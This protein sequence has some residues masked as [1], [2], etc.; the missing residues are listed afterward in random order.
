MVLMSMGLSFI[1]LIMIIIIILEN[2]LVIIRLLSCR[3]LWQLVTIH[4]HQGRISQEHE[5]FLVS[6]YGILPHEV[7]TSNLVKVNS[8]GDILETPVN[9][10]TPSMTSPGTVATSQAGVDK[11]EFRLHSAVYASRPDARCL[12][13]L[14]NVGAVSVSNSSSDSW[15]IVFL[16]MA[17]FTEDESRRLYRSTRRERTNERTNALGKGRWKNTCCCW[18]IR[19]F[20]DGKYWTPLASET[21]LCIHCSERTWKRCSLLITFVF[22][23]MLLLHQVVA[24]RWHSCRK[25]GST[26]C[27]NLAVRPKCFTLPT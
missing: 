5:R 19:R 13:H 11:N 12:I 3:W 7:T 1:L 18:K 4:H 22:I 20:N 25:S 27:V 10:L 9:P 2:R 16:W 26:M 15:P 6:T 8:K 23:S 17:L 14:V 24:K 21:P